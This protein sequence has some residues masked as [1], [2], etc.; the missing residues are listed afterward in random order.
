LAQHREWGSIQR[1]IEWVNAPQ[2]SD[3]SNPVAIPGSLTYETGSDV[4]GAAAFY[5]QQMPLAGYQETSTYIDAE[6]TRLQYSLNSQTTTV[7]IRG[8]QP[9]T[10]QVVLA[11]KQPTQPAD[12]TVWLSD[13]GLSTTYS[14]DRL[15]DDGW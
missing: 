6:Y 15:S 2:L 13:E 5:Q 10:V 3:I 4:A 9:T 7:Y 12:P 8:G 14:G 1:A 11:S